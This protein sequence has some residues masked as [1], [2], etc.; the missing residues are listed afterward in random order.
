MPRKR[1]QKSSSKIATTVQ[2][3]QSREY[4][5]AAQIISQRLAKGGEEYLKQNLVSNMIASSKLADEAEFRDL[6]MDSNQVMQVTERWLKK[7]NRRLEAAE[8]K[9]S[10]AHNEVS[11]D[12]RIEIISELAT[13]PFRQEVHRRLQALLDRLMAGR[14]TKKL[15]MVMMLIPALQMK[16]I[17]WGLCAL[18][19]E[20]YS[21]TM[22]R[23]LQEYKEELE[24]LDSVTEALKAEGEE[25]ID[26]F[27]LLKHPNKLHEIGVKAFKNRP[28]LRRRAEKQVWDM[29][30]AFENA[31][32]NGD[33]DLSLFSEDELLL[34]FQQVEAEFGKPFTELQFSDA[35]RDRVVENIRRAVA[36][37]MTPQRFHRFRED[38]ERAAANWV[39]ARQKWGAA[40]QVELSFLDGDE[41][42]ENKFIL[43]AF[44]GQVSRMGK[45][46]DQ[47]AKKQK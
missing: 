17:P 15:E 5:P 42:E 22:D 31:L 43:A 2:P 13:P 18:I 8:E 40:L 46:N 6:Y 7:Y 32:G 24:I 35:T 44:V 10:D 14:D 41:Y 16:S 1:H 34:P 23:A 38:V 19:Q 27:T 9:G 11:D 20:I 47:T 39:R 3:M 25:K 33:V 12:M 29:I 4:S 36:E 37:I 28:G 26:I 30:D 21:R 45:E